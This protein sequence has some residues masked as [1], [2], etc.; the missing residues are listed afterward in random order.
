MGPTTKSGKRLG[1]KKK[2]GGKKR[3][4]E[5]P[6]WGTGSRRSWDCLSHV[7]ITCNS[8]P[9]PS[10]L[11][12]CDPW[13]EPFAA[14]WTKASP[15]W[16]NIPDRALQT[17]WTDRCAVHATSLS[18][19]SPISSSNSGRPALDWWIG[20]RLARRPA[21]RC[22]KPGLVVWWRVFPEVRTGLILV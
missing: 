8:I 19:S 16:I 20:P 10:P 6:D 12:F 14:L 13:N 17:R 5:H 15:L 9:L 21:S 22:T 4:G 1:C 7:V 18:S 2:N 11:L 3:N